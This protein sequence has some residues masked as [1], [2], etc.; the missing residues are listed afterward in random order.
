MGG[1]NMKTIDLGNGVECTIYEGGDKYWYLNG[2]QH[3]TDGPAIEYS[4][5]DKSWYLNDKCHR[6]DGPA[7]EWG[8][9]RKAWYLNGKYHRTDGPAIEDADGNKQWYLNGIE[10]S[11]EDFEQVKEV[12]WAV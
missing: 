9:D 6:T 1:N 10:Y 12:L 2:K 7:I 5:G 8:N 11:E 3:R 4:N